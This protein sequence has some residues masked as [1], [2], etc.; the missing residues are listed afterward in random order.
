M[1][2][3]E[4]G[5]FSELPL[6]VSLLVL[7]CLKERETPPSKVLSQSHPARNKGR[8]SETCYNRECWEDSFLSIYEFK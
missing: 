2:L 7:T 1:Y 4:L 8:Q 6:E 5:E 3:D